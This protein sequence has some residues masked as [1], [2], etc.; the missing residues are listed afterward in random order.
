MVS[1]NPLTL[2]LASVMQWDCSLVTWSLTMFLLEISVNEV[3]LD[4]R[5]RVKIAA[6]AARGIA[7]LHED[8]NIFRLNSFFINPLN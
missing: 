5:T 4:W 6:G 2:I 1:E 3:P 7:Y 8:C